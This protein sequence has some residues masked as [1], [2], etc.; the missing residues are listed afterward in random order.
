M[1]FL[2]SL[3]Q[4]ARYALRGIRRS[5]AF[6][7]VAVLSLALG[8]GANTAIFSLIDAVILRTLP[9]SHPEQLVEPLTQFPQAGEPRMNGWGAPHLAHFREH[10]HVFSGVIAESMIPLTE[11]RGA[12]G[13]PRAVTGTFVDGTYFSVL[14]VR[15]AIGRLIGVE[16]DRA[17][18]GSAVAVIGWQWWRDR[19]YFDPG[20]LGR[21][22]LVE[23]TPVTVI[24]VAPRGFVGLQPWYPEDAF[25][26][27]ALQPVVHHLPG[28]G[29]GTP[30]AIVGRLKPGVTIEQARSEMTVLFHQLGRDEVRTSDNV[31]R[32]VGFYLEPAG[33][34]LSQLR[35]LYARPLVVLMAVVGLLLMIACTNLA[36]M[37]L[38]RGAARQRELA[39]RVSLGAGRFRLAGQVLTESLLLSIGGSLLGVLVASYGTQALVRV[40]GS[41]RMHIDLDVGPDVRVVLFTAAVG[42]L[43]GLLFGLAP[44]WHALATAPASSLR[45]TGRV[46]ES[47][48]RRLFGKGLVAAQVALSMVLLSAAGLFTNHL[49]RLR[50]PDSGLRRDHVLV[51]GVNGRGSGYTT[52]RLLQGYRELLS[53]L[54]SIPGVRTATFSGIM[55]ISLQGGPRIVSVEGYQPTPG[56][57]RNISINW[58]AP[59]YFAT[60]GIPLLLGRDFTGRD[61]GGPPAVIIS[62]TMARYYFSNASPLGKH[63]S[64][65]GHTGSYAIIG[66]AADAKYSDLHEPMVRVAYVDEFQDAIPSGNL[67][68]RTSIDPNAVAGAAVRMVRQIL[69]AA[70]VTRVISLQ[71]QIDRSIIPE[72]LV[73]ALS[74]L[75]GALGTLLAAIGLYGLLAYT[76]ARRI[77]EI[78]VRMALG[79]TA[80][81]VT[82]MV[83]LDA[84]AMVGAGLAAGVPLVLWCKRFAASVVE[85]LH[86]EIAI[87][88]IVGGLAL[89][90]AGLVAAYL[91][92]RRAAG[93]DPVVALRY[94]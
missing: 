35:D 18:A 79:A 23:K 31:L 81:D 80:R 50:G 91:P 42:L 20:V 66:V 39:L 40:I 5:K 75:F 33:G 55:P 3:W 12:A 71:D 37:L 87:P 78:G 45:D 44:A 16:D 52:E 89:I 69:P 32:R 2:E 53:H 1:K 60:L 36:A 27:L 25:L 7:A 65:D 72:R 51:V 58:V 4:D 88:V 74:G 47:R 13:D 41:G 11:V 63:L 10:N 85:G 64:F 43:T 15:A 38:A 76:V 67:A 21:Q 48:R 90:V 82:R 28:S 92:A 14:G 19:F 6:T 34:G 57:R 77:H 24:G 56:E 46:G 17:G 9:V 26:P 73:A 84:L 59:N 83:L 54:A 30:R 49:A 62:Q 70:P 29:D 94:E 68:L 61:D 86:M 93:V 22:I 8:I